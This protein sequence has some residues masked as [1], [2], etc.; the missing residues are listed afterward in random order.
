MK[1]YHVSMDI[2]VRH[3]R[4]VVELQATG[5]VTAA[6]GRL[7]VT[8]SAV[9]HQLREL[10]N[11]MGC[12]I[13]SRV[14]RRLVL[15][16]AGLRLLRAAESVLP[17]L[18][19]TTEDVGRIRSG[20]MGLL[21]ICAQCHTGYHWLPPLLRRFQVQHPGIEVEV[22]VQHTSDPVGA[23]LGGSLDLALVTDRVDD[24]RLEVRP[25]L[26]D[27]H[28]ALVAPGHPWASLAFV[29]PEQLGRETLLLYSSSPA[30]SFTVRRILA[31]AGVRP[32]RIRFVQLTEAILAM[33]RADLGVSV[34]PRWSVQPAL[35]RGDVRAVRITS[36][37]VHRQWS[38]VTRRHPGEPQYLQD[39]LKLMPKATSGLRER[40]RPLR[41][42]QTSR[43]CRV[44]P[45]GGGRQL[46]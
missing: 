6:A 11:R 8:Q 25:L 32:A 39:F 27:E 41:Q 23:L 33:V 34:M 45:A 3:L 4:L 16:P 46:V 12:E 29:T 30:D 15:S 40:N 17:E 13:C 43:R 22:A 31:P 28:V 19:R 36:R 26:T 1:L 18:E 37:G 21:R 9:S 35:D 44:G 42:R 2:D 10:G 14:G 24:E 7:G 20:Q 5:S 38:A